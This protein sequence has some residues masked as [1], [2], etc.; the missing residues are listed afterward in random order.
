[1]EEEPTQPSTQPFL[2]PRRLGQNASMSISDESDVICILHPCSP[3]AYKAVELVTSSTPQHILQNVGLSYILGEEILEEM[4]ESPT[5]PYEYQEG[6]AA[7]SVRA[8][9]GGNSDRDTQDH[10]LVDNLTTRRQSTTRDIALRLSSKVK[11]PCLGFA[12]GRNPQRCDLLLGD[13]HEHKH[14]SNMH[15]RI[16]LNDEGVIMLED[17]ST[18]GTVVENIILKREL[19]TE[20]DSKNVDVAADTNEVDAINVAPE[21]NPTTNAPKANAVSEVPSTRM[22]MLQQGSIIQLLTK[23]PAHEIKFIIGIPTR[24]HAGD[25]YQRNLNEYIAY[26]QQAKRQA[27]AHA[28]AK[29]DTETVTAP[30][31][32][33]NFL[34]SFT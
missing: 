16:F 32:S 6:A 22:M 3:A 8:D 15:F 29:L 2:D 27:A 1:M 14:I 10:M 28:Q 18:N 5:R 19:D 30:K 25:R 17:T 13:L 9:T 4:P 24:D 11:D 23:N 20:L 21:M 34:G 12:F 7:G 26:V 33:N 31:V